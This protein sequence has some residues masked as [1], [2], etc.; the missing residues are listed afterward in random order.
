[1]LPRRYDFWGSRNGKWYVTCHFSSYII[2]LE[3]TLCSRNISTYCNVNGPVGIIS[4]LVIDGTGRELL[5]ELGYSII[6]I[7]IAMPIISWLGSRTAIKLIPQRLLTYPFLLAVIGS[8]MRYV[9][10]IAGII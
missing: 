9:I 5:D 8:L 7:A 6:I 3:A 1:M 10:D 2:F 4:H